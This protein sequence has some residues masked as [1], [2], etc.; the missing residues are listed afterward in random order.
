MQPNYRWPTP[1]GD[2][3]IEKDN[4]HPWLWDLCFNGAPLRKGYTDPDKAA[5]EANQSDVG[6]EKINS[7]LRN[8]FAPSDLRQWM[9]MPAR[10]FQNSN[11]NN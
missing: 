8:F 10:T 1:K 6:D 9:Q 11:Q 7:F 2:L 5:W 4:E 3:T